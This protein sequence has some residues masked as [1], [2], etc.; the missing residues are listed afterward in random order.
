M[1]KKNIL[2]TQKKS[3]NCTNTEYKNVTFSLLGS[4]LRSF[5]HKHIIWCEDGINSSFGHLADLEIVSRFNPSSPKCAIKIGNDDL[6]SQLHPPS[7]TMLSLCFTPIYPDI[8]WDS[9]TSEIPFWKHHKGAKWGQKLQVN[10]RA[11]PKRVLVKLTW[12]CCQSIH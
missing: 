1:E 8:T 4:V 7:F 6:C 12:P 2:R 10:S 3:L 9:S 11:G 5:V